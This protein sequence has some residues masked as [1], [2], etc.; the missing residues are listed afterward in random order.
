MKAYKAILSASLLVILCWSAEAYY[1]PELG[2]WLS[3]DPF[4]ERG[5]KNLYVF[6]RNAPAASYDALGLFAPIIT[7]DLIRLGYL[8][9]S[10]KCGW[11][12]PQHS[13]E[14]SWEAG[15]FLDKLLAAKAG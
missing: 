1:V 2:K 8:F 12:D 15:L 9:Y 14:Y 6:V 5:G 3:R 7:T 13:E 11:I 10:C 4:Q